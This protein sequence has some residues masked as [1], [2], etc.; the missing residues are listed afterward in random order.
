[1]QKVKRQK[2][3][4][5]GFKKKKKAISEEEMLHLSR[6]RYPGVGKNK[7][8]STHLSPQDFMSLSSDA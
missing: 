1:M 3:Q 8:N 5:E 4:E 7:K 6:T 2:G